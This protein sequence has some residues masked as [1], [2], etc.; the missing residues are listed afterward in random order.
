M[1]SEKN[2]TSVWFLIGRTK[3]L[4]FQPR[5]NWSLVGKFSKKTH[6]A[7]GDT[8]KSCCPR[9]HGCFNSVA[10][11]LNAKRWGVYN[12][13]KDLVQ[14]ESFGDLIQGV[15]WDDGRGNESRQTREAA[16]RDGRSHE[17]RTARQALQGTRPNKQTK[18]KDK[19]CLCP[20]QIY[21]LLRCFH[22]EKPTR[23]VKWSPVS[24]FTLQIGLRPVALS[25]ALSDPS[26]QIS[27]IRAR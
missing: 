6:C 20:M 13:S 9:V 15:F 23:F 1:R 4:K 21:I 3:A 8:P 16:A 14:I 19:T 10:I 17:P 27:W 7:L 26:Q 2:P 5:T 18:Q 11:L 24:L 12:L 25:S 22:S